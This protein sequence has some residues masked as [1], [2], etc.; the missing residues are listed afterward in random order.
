M[1]ISTADFVGG[2]SLAAND[3]LALR[4]SQTRDYNYMPAITFSCTY[5][6]VDTVRLCDNVS[7]HFWCRSAGD[8]ACVDRRARCA[9]C[10][11]VSISLGG[12]RGGYNL[13]P[14]GN[15]GFMWSWNKFI[16]ARRLTNLIIHNTPIQFCWPANFQ[17]IHRCSASVSCH[18]AIHGFTYGFAARRNGQVN[19]RHDDRLRLSV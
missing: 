8:R 13:L 6:Y 4:G 17:Q 14:G 11:F 19:D 7:S 18:T 12:Y 16:A 9:L 15:C 10:Q 1:R 5:P 2:H 3:A